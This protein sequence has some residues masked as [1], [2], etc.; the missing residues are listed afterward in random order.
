MTWAAPLFLG[1]R[2]LRVRAGRADQLQAH[3]AR[4]LAGDQADA[5]GGRMEQHE[6]AFLQAALRLRALEQVLRGEALEHHGRAGVEVDRIGQ[7]AH[8]LGRHH[9]QL[10]IA[11]GRLAGVGGAVAGLQVRDARAHGLD[12]AG[13]F[14]AQRR[15]HLQRVQAGAVVDVDEV[16]ADR[17]VADAD[18]AGARLAHLHVDDLQLF[19]TAGLGDLYGFAHG[20]SF[21]GD[22]PRILP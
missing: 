20:A 11:A 16:Q 9:A 4:P 18:F 22:Q 1:Q 3:R 6:V 10:A 14:H 17:L 8:A 7:L 12:D 2:A 5:A 19:R 21:K 13:R 15:G